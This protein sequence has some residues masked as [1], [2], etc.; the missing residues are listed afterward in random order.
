[1]KI[2]LN[3]DNYFSLENTAISASKVRD[4]LKSKEL[5][6]KRY[7][8]GEY[9]PDVTPSLTLGKLVDECIEHGSLDWF[10]KNY[11]VAVLKKDNPEL[12]AEQKANP[13]RVI[14]EDTYA[15]VIGMC[16]RILRSPFF[17][18]YNTLIEKNIKVY[19]QFPLWMPVKTDDG[20]FD[21]CGM[22][23]LLT[24]RYEGKDLVA[25]IDDLKTTNMSSIR[26]SKSWAWHVMEYGYHRQMANYRLL[27]RNA[28]PE[29]ERIVCRHF[30]IANSK[31]DCFPIR[32]FT[33]SEAMLNK[34]EAEFL[35]V[36]E[37]ISKE[38]R[39]IDELPSWKDAVEIPDVSGEEEVEEL[40]DN[41]MESL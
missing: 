38:Q 6:F 9:A 25:Y 21:I 16:D 5:Y 40:S 34:G 8:S 33:F 18:F 37:E 31:A 30:V 23:D 36:A 24:I 29:V 4:F 19:H 28:F 39:F 14:S 3:R 27:V 10:K 2:S 32:L 11:T 20:E 7:V 26:S 17:E 13:E 1:M 12:Y 22:L 35:K 41:E 15:R